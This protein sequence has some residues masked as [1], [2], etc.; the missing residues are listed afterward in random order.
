MSNELFSM[1]QLSISGIA[2]IALFFFGFVLNGFRE[3]LRDLRD[4]VKEANNALM[5][6]VSDYKIH[7]GR[8]A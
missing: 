6:H 2:S 7:Q 5:S 4:D 1:I 3:D 8:N